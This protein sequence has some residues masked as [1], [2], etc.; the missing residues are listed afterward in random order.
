MYSMA[1]LMKPSRT[2]G[3]H[4]RMHARASI[5]MIGTAALIAAIAATF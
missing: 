4:L 3:F 2:F 5:F 1:E